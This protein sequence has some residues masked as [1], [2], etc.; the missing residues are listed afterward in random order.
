MDYLHRTLAELNI[1]YIITDGGLLGSL[2][3]GN[4][5]DWDMDIDLHI[6]SEDFEKIPHILVPRIH[7]DGFFI[8]LHPNEESY[9]VQANEHNHLYIEL[10]RRREFFDDS[11]LVPVRDK[12]YRAMKHPVTNVTMWY[13]VDWFRNKLRTVFYGSLE[14]STHEMLCSVPGH[15]NCVDQRPSGADCK[16]VGLC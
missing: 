3:F 9:V 13:G 8:R 11:W 15:H 1:K 2:K 6:R 7:A 10:N 14:D 4:L 16:V 12:L 5:L